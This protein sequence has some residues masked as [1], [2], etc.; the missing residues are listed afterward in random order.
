VRLVDGFTTQ[1]RHHHRNSRVF[2][3]KRAKA[4]SNLWITGQLLLVRQSTRYTHH[5]IKAS[6]PSRT[7]SAES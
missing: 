4:A 5:H 2:L 1:F 7:F 3:V 6:I